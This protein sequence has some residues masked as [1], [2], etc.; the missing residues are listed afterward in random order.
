[1]SAYV[2]ANLLNKVEKRYKNRASLGSILPPF[3]NEFN[4]FNRF[5][6]SYDT[7]ITVKLCLL[8]LKLWPYIHRGSYTSDHF[9]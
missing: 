1:M 9:I 5:Y 6:L 4:G 8:H 7:K 3:P 2:L